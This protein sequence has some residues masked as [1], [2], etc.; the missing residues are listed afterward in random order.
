MRS[1]ALTVLF[2]LCGSLCLGQA[3]RC[4]WS[5]VGIGGGE[6]NSGAY[7]CVATA[8]QTAAGFMTS[9]DYWALVGY[10]LPEGQVGV[11]ESDKWSD[12]Q[13]Q[14][15]HLYSPFP[16][17]FARS[18]TI[19]YSLAT[20]EPAALQVYDGV[21]RLVRS[22]AVS[23]EPSATSFVTWDGRDARGQGLANGVY[24]LRLQAGDYRQTEKLV[25][26]R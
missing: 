15:T 13:V 8:G 10:W 25:L 3:Y 16:T 22:W 19:R 5:V 14:V 1:K 7:R 17:P 26:Q 4:D 23:H 11:Q 6:M 12:G 24:F 21:G 20:D 9:P 18:V 2:A